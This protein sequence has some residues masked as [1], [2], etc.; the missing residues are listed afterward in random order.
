M[1]LLGAA[2]DLTYPATHVGSDPAALAALA[3]GQHPFLE[4]LKKAARPAVVV[5]PGVLRRPD[6]DAVM[7]AVHELCKTAGAA[8]GRGLP[9][10]CSGVLDSS[11]RG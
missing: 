10:R 3:A 8:G 9:V 7:K 1:G 11:S 4:E 2:V 6:R 5:G